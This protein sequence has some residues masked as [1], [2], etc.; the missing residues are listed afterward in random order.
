MKTTIQETIAPFKAQDNSGTL[1][2]I[3]HR[4]QE[5][6]LDNDRSKYNFQLCGDKTVLT[7]AS[8]ERELG[9]VIGLQCLL[10]LQMFAKLHQGLDYLQVFQ[11]EDANE[12]LWVIEDGVAITALL[13]SDY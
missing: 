3:T 12:N 1:R 5:I 2:T 4:P 8:L 10:R 7:T 11:V 6:P 13:P 9:G